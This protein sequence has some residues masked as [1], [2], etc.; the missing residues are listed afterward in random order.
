[1]SSV[2]LLVHPDRLAAQE[3]G[4]TA[5]SWWADRGYVVHYFGDVGDASRAA[6]SFP[7]EAE[8]PDFVISFGG[9][10]TMLRA[11]QM[12]LPHGS[13]VLGINLGRMGYLTEVDPPGMT[14]AFER[15]ASGDF[16][17]EE[18]MAIEVTTVRA[19]GTNLAPS[20]AL[21]EAI[22]ERVAP[23]HTIR[24]EVSIGGRT[25]LTYTADGLL[26]CTPTGS[27]AYNLSARGPVV[28]PTMRALVLTPL[29]PHLAFDR[30]LVLGPDETIAFR[31]LD[32][33]PAVLALDGGGEV[34]LGEGDKV[35]CRA[36]PAA[37]RFVVLH[38]RDF[39]AVLRTRFSILDT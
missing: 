20:V 11:V 16:K 27:T 39:H 28:S 23:G 7:A 1:V 13:P 5:R 37:V 22:V 36:A 3:L 31:L 38:E 6:E 15:M 32:A 24:V 33:R 4:E 26:V 10:G 9:D 25:F 34:T 12:A 29:A 35:T 21:N 30:S 8:S 19:D 2:L 14:S 18:R 17:V